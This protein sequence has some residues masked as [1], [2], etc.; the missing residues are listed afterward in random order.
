MF[1]EL[2]AAVQDEGRTVFISSHAVSDLERFAD[3]IGMIRGGRLVFEASTAEVAERFRLVDFVVDRDVSI[4][5]LPG[6]VVQEQGEGRTRA[7]VDLNLGGLDAI[8][9]LGARRLTESPVSLE[10]LFVALG[11]A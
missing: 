9:S 11:R 7:L 8:R 3:H 2:L 4:A 5:G 10:D 6:M 1:A